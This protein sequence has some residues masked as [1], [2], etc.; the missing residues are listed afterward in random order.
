MKSDRERQI[1]YITYMGNL[2]YGRDELTYETKTDS[3]STGLRLSR[4]RREVEGWSGI[5]RCKLLYIEWINHKV[6]LYSTGNTAQYSVISHNG[7]ETE[8]HC[9]IT[10]ITSTL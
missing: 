4:G 8:S 3:L 10:A 6:L 1:S 7:K 5:S 9:Y 2:K